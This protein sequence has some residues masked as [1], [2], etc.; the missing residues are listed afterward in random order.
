MQGEQA[1][2]KERP[3]KE[4][5]VVTMAQGDYMVHVY[6]QTGKTFLLEGETT[7]NPYI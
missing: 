6:I 5:S 1:E 4:M 3:P 7:C 2:G